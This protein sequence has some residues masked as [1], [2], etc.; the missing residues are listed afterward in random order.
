MTRG[1]TRPLSALAEIPVVP[2]R[3]P[4][5]T[6]P[7][8]SV[9]IPTFNGDAL[10]ER[11]LASVLAQA[12][13]PDEMHIEVVDDASTAAD[14]RAVVDRIGR[15]RVAFSSQERN[16]GPARN[17]TACVQRARGEWVHVLH[18]DDIVLPGFYEAYR[19]HI[20]SHPCTMAVA[21]SFTVNER[22]EYLGVSPPLPQADGYLLH[23]PQV[24]AV[25]HPVHC[26][27]VV[28]RRDAYEQV[29][30]FRPALAHAADWEMWTRLAGSGPVACVPGA[31][32]LYRNHPESDTT[33]LQESMSYLTDALDALAVIETRFD[34]PA[35]LAQLRETARTR[36]SRQALELAAR[37]AQEGRRRDALTNAG[38]GWRI[39]PSLS[40]S[41]AVAEILW[42]C[43]R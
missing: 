36:L 14:P 21:Q 29:G 17:F 7:F 40:A 28:A 1:R 26:V 3:E 22:D 2:P 38:W 15:G 25:H 8:W 32:A 31:H 39:H 9:M 27:A 42:A 16:V 24:I 18:G 6:R 19:R 34:D 10:L 37:Y 13:G 35:T 33:R 12:P 11:T 23:P 43:V 30:G 20:A 5:E 41:A 4:D